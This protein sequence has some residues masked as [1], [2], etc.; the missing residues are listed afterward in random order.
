MEGELER[1]L[2]EELGPRRG[3]RGP[4]SGLGD[5]SFSDAN[6]SGRAP[7]IV[8]DTGKGSRVEA[9]GIPQGRVLEGMKPPEGCPPWMTP[10][11]LNLISRFLEQTFRNFQ[12]NV[13]PPSHIEPPFTSRPIDAFPA[14]IVAIPGVAF[15]DVVAFRVPFSRRRGEIHFA[16]Q[17]AESAAAFSDLA[18]RILVNGIPLDPWQ[19][20]R[21]QL[22][23]M[24]PPTQLCSPIH[25]VAG[26]RIV[27]Q[28]RSISGAAHSV[29]GRLC[30]WHYQV[31]SESGNEVKSTLV[32]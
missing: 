19:D 8:G 18:W 13:R 5:Y 6:V 11:C 26:D 23:A 30:G 7:G 20:V 14:A 32:D 21:I 29:L 22:W 31:R 16:G 9:Y 27:L 10:D 4:D 28:A 24:V 3:K 2:R 25:L 17:S 15:V 1:V 12:T